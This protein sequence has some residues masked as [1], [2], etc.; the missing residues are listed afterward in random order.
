MR[1]Y[2][3]RRL[4]IVAEA[5]NILARRQVRWHFDHIEDRWRLPG[6]VACRRLERVADAVAAAAAA[7]LWRLSSG[8]YDNQ[9]A[10]AVKDGISPLVGLLGSD[11]EEAQMQAEEP[12]A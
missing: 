1:A 8:H 12:E 7:V 11:A 6:V 4:A 5:E 2:L 10:I 9:K 3:C